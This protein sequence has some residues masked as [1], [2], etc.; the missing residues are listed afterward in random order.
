MLTP[1]RRPDFCERG[2]MHLP[3]VLDPFSCLIHPACASV[4]DANDENGIDLP[5]RRE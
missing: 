3:C 4:T 2:P 1:K 5:R